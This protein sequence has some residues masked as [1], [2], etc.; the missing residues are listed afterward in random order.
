LLLGM[1]KIGAQ[2]IDNGSTLC[3]TV[4][5]H[6]G[7]YMIKFF[8]G[9]IVGIVVATVG[10]TGLANMADKGVAKTKEI[11]VDVAK[12]DTVAEAKKAASQA[13]KE[14]TK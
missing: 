14:V 11:A 5:I 3:Y 10:F 12:S 8:L 13:V 4:F 7:D 6:T 1:H 2:G 9:I